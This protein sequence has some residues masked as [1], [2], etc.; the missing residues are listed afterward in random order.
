MKIDVIVEI[1]THV[2]PE[3]VG[4]PNVK[5]MFLQVRQRGFDFYNKG[6]SNL[7]YVFMKVFP[8]LEVLLISGKI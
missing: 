2:E 1:Q 8:D 3:D 5:M 7:E 6:N 4:K